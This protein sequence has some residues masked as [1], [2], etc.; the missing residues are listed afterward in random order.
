MEQ[1]STPKVLMENEKKKKNE[2]NGE[3]RQEGK[4]KEKKKYKLKVGS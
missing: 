2:Y 4:K 3:I 1:I